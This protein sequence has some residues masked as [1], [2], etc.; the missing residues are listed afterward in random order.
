MPKKITS[1]FIY[2]KRYL[3][4]YLLIL[5]TIATA[6]ISLL[7]APAGLRQEEMVNVASNA[8]F[9]KQ[10]SPIDFLYNLLQYQL[11]QWLGLSILVV[12]LPSLLFGALSLIGLF[13]LISHWINRKTAIIATI[14]VI[15]TTQLSII[16]QDATPLIM[17]LFWQISVL[18]ILTK[19]G[20]YLNL[21]KKQLSHKVFW[22]VLGLVFVIGL[23]LY[24]PTMLYFYL[25]IVAVSIA[26]PKIRLF[27]NFLRPQQSLIALTVLGLI[28]APLVVNLLAHPNLAQTFLVGNGYGNFFNQITLISGSNFTIPQ[29]SLS[30]GAL[31]IAL[32]GGYYSLRR[33]HLA[34]S[35]F[36][37]S[38]TLGNLLLNLFITSTT[39]TT[40]MLYGILLMAYGVDSLIADWNK[41]FPLNPYPRIL[42]VLIISISVAII[43]SAG[44][45]RLFKDYAYTPNIAGKFNQDLNLLVSSLDSEKKYQLLAAD[46]VE[47][48][49]YRQLQLRNLSHAIYQKDQALQP[50]TILT[51]TA[52]TNSNQLLPSQVWTNSFNLQADRFYLY[53]K[54]QK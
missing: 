51:R 18:V 38:A 41:L 12:K 14:L 15:T 54:S 2:Q 23:S 36:V 35:T 16:A 8:D 43:A 1:Y 44:F 6:T 49:F 30:I 4:G 5:L 48:N 46:E 7:Y 39:Y 17:P 21:N 53:Q 52:Y 32:I 13:W 3:I 47:Y 20:T 25:I 9:W 10:L 40:L 22:I 28:T 11:I 42:G 24:T 34:P 27:I 50:N 45:Y 33:I 37:L 26:H 31:I 19:L 29:P